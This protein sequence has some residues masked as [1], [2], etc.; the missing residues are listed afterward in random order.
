MSSGVTTVR[1]V[2]REPFALEARTK[3][4]LEVPLAVRLWALASRES[5]LVGLYRDRN[6]IAKSSEVIHQAVSTILSASFTRSSPEMSLGSS[7]LRRAVR[8]LDSRLLCSCWAQHGFRS[9]AKAC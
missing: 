5:V 3:F 1:A 6:A 7:V 4:N 9:S 2:T 8:V